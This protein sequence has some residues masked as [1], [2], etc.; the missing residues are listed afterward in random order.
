MIKYV[1][2]CDIC[3]KVIPVGKE[4]KPRLLQCNSIHMCQECSSMI[5]D[6]IVRFKGSVLV[7][8][9]VSVNRNDPANM[10]CLYCNHYLINEHIFRAFGLSAPVC[11]CK[12]SSKFLSQVKSTQRCKF[13]EW[14]IEK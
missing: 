7:D 11:T 2:I 8:G 3:G 12:Q 9:K 5:D 14:Y 1:K 10:R 6:G 4:G 13:F